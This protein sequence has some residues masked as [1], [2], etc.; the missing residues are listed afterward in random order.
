MDSAE[1]IKK[2]Q[3][4]VRQFESQTQL[5]QLDKMATVGLLSAGIAHEINNPLSAMMLVFSILGSQ[6]VE[7]RKHLDESHVPLDD[8]TQALFRDMD[9]FI[10]QGRRCADTIAKIVTTV[11]TFAVSDKG[12]SDLEDI[13]TIMD[14]VIGVV[15]N[16]VDN[17]VKIVK[18]YGSLPK[19]RC[20]SQQLSQAFLNLLLNASQAM[21]SKGVIT[22]KTSAEGKNICMKISD[23]GYGMT[24]DVMDKIFEP[25]FTTKGEEEGTGLGLWTTL[26]VV[27]KHSGD[28]RVESVVGKGTTFTILLPI[29]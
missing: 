19:I 23:T 10:Q 27:K 6:T 5:M 9:E 24:R 21:D 17:K 15:W 18:E 8:R 26:D 3:E 16:A 14:G 28:I 12:I 13:H 22:I 2:L 20:N 25:F 29:S 7:L 4:R 1:S 11:R